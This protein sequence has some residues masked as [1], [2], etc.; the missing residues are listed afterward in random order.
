MKTLTI[1]GYLTR[2]ADTMVDRYLE[3]FGA[4][5]IEGP[6]W[7]GKTSTAKN[8]AVSETSMANPEGDFRERT[9]A[10]LEPS[11]AI[12]GERPRLIDEWQDVPKLWDAVRYECD[13]SASKGIYILTGSSTSKKRK[14]E[15][16]TEKQPRHSG[17]GRIARIRMGTMTLFEQGI[18]SGK[19]SL[20]GLFEG[21]GYSGA[22]RLD[23]AAIAEIVVRGGWPAAIGMKTEDAALISKE[24]LNAVVEEDVH[25]VDGV[26]RDR[27]KI[28]KLISSLARNEATLATSKTIMKDMADQDESITYPTLKEYLDVLRRMFFVDDIRPWDPAL[29]SPVKI[30]AAAKHHLAD[31]SLAAAAL[32]ASPEALMHDPKTLGFLFESLVTHDVL[33][34]AEAIGAKVRHYRDETGLEVDLVVAKPDGDWIAMEVKLGMDQVE[35]AAKSLIAARKK[36][37]AKGERPPRALVVVVGS[38]GVAHMREDGVQVAPIDTLG[39]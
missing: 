31:P 38:G 26:E 36:L 22:S 27:D 2:I 29:R 15:D 21:E 7:C 10:E 35:K 3:V 32:G 9:I 4:V 5:V 20:A 14:G 37:V 24:Y 6:K 34:Y 13:K 33:V 19:V 8:H 30:R 12:S 11:L 28:R 1:D 25:E 39:I 18:S 16:S 17:A 23:L